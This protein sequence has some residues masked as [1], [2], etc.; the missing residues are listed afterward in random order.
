MIAWFPHPA[1]KQ[2]DTDIDTERDKGPYMTH[3]TGKTGNHETAGQ[4]GKWQKQHAE[5]GVICFFSQRL[6][7]SMA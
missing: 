2:T 6:A 7:A 3:S 5:N 1:R 4:A